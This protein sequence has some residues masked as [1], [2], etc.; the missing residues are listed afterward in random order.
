MKNAAAKTLMACAI[1]IP[2]T[3]MVAPVASADTGSASGSSSGSAT[4]SAAVGSIAC[5]FTAA[6][7]RLFEPNAQIPCPLPNLG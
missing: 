7:V 4:G 1:V 6:V 5:S 3:T 2:L